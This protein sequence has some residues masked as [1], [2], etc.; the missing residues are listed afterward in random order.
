MTQM[1]NWLKHWLTDRER[2]EYQTYQLNIR[3]EYI[4][5]VE[6]AVLVWVIQRRRHSSEA[7]RDAD[8]CHKCRKP[9]SIIVSE[10]LALLFPQGSAAV[11]A[12]TQNSVS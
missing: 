9:S 2:R 8:F 5:Y 11:G 7:T 12:Q 1:I 4:T 3:Y 10:F 6:E